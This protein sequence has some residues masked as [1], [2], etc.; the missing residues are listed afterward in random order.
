MAAIFSSLLCGLGASGCGMDPSVLMASPKG[1]VAPMLLMVDTVPSGAQAQARNGMSC[2]TPCELTVTAM[3]PFMVDFTLKNYE[4]LS[5][6]VV[7]APLNPSD[8]SAGI[9]LDPNPLTVE[10]KAI[11]PASP[12]PKQRPVAKQSKPKPAWPETAGA[13]WPPAASR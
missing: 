2:Q 6:E 7:L 5:V 4:P 3:G 1:S 10:L 9:R 13:I 12:P 11:P 8:L